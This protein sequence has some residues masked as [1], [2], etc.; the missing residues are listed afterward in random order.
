MDKVMYGLRKHLIEE[1][2]IDS[3][4]WSKHCPRC[5]KVCDSLKALSRYANV[6]VCDDCGL[7]EALNAMT[8]IITDFTDWAIYETV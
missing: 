5:G 1:L 4:K 3:K 2:V 7:T 6:A 8:G